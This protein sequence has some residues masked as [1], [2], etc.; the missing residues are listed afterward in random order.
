MDKEKARAVL[1]EALRPYRAKS[2]AELRDLIGQNDV[3]Q[4]ENPEHPDGRQCHVPR[5]GRGSD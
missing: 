4:I 2:Y 5:A 3:Y 1:S